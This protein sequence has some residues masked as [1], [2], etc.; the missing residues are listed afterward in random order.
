MRGDAVTVNELRNRLDDLR[1]KRAAG[2]HVAEYSGRRIEYC[3]DA[4][5]G[6]AI[7]GLERLLAMACGVRTV[8]V[9]AARRG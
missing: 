7:L 3:S 9:P 6:A 8:R 4:E 5:M 1:S 2:I